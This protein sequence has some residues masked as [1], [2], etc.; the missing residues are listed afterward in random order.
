ML[1]P[2]ASQV[3]AR[4]AETH[5]TRTAQPVVRCA[6]ARPKATPKVERD[7]LTSLRLTSLPTFNLTLQLIILTIINL[8]LRLLRSGQQQLL[9]H[10]S[11]QPSPPPS[12]ARRPRPT[13][14]TTALYPP[15]STPVPSRAIIIATQS[16]CPPPLLA[17][18]GSLPRLRHALPPSRPSAS[19]RQSTR[20]L[21]RL[22]AACR[23]SVT[24]YR[25]RLLFRRSIVRE[26]REDNQSAA[27]PLLEDIAISR[28][29]SLERHKWWSV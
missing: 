13:R 20:L 29:A 25:G 4:R 14:P 26:A 7:H 12:H 19:P 2:P 22:A 23:C 15:A 6:S 9:S 16:L 1:Q 17:S 24:F 10:Q 11:R 21:V 8:R 3:P 28:H 5:K 27:H 18:S